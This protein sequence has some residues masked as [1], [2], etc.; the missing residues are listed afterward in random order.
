MCRNNSEKTSKMT[1]SYK[2]GSS[3]IVSNNWWINPFLKW[4]VPLSCKYLG[5]L[6]NLWLWL[7]TTK[8]FLLLVF[9]FRWLSK[10]SNEW[11]NEHLSLS[12]CNTLVKPFRRPTIRSQSQS[13]FVCVLKLANIDQYIEYEFK[14][15]SSFMF[16]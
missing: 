5:Y 12:K 15:K 14:L 1:N 2:L 9:I 10:Q 4:K 16:S 13:R 7:F 11:I 6:G 8:P 3:S